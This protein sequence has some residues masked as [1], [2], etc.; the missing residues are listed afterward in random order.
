MDELSFIA[1]IFAVLLIL[2]SIVQ[3]V[4]WRERAKAFLI[5][6]QL[7]EITEEFYLANCKGGLHGY[8]SGELTDE[9]KAEL[10]EELLENL[11]KDK[12]SPVSWKPTDI[13]VI[14]LVYHY[15]YAFGYQVYKA[16]TGY[17]TDEEREERLEREA[18]AREAER[19]RLEEMER[20]RIAAEKDAKK[21]ANAIYLDEKMRKEEEKKQR[22]VD[23]ARDAAEAEEKEAPE[24]L[25]VNGK[26]TS[27][28]ELRK[29]GHFL[30]HIAHSGDSAQLVVVDKSVVVGQ[31]V[32]VALEGAT[33]PNGK[34]VKRNKL[35][36][37]W[38]EGVLLEFESGG[39]ADASADDLA[40]PAKAIEEPRQRKKK[41]RGGV[42]D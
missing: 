12:D 29:K 10:K 9:R 11:H 40:E 3:I 27:V 14:C 32:R 19:L 22:W 42:R 25:I 34:T 16:V 5:S 20:Q 24:E 23:E 37:E 31:K 13:L 2:V 17:E 28:D 38:N 4:H 1:V 18:A 26:I 33:L 8:Q 7:D 41:T 30:V 6:P 15:P 39:D 21:S 35:G 36:G